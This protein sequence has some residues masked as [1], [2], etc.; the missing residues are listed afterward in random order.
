M[1]MTP[2]RKGEMFFHD[3][4]LCFQNW[5]SCSSCHP[6]ART[7]GLNWDL[8]NDGMGN[9]KQTKSMLLAHRT[10]P[11]MMGAVRENAEAA[12]RAGIRF[13]QFS[14]RPEE[15]AV[16]IDEYLKSLK[17]VPSPH[18]VD[19][20]LSDG[21]K[22]GEALFVST[23]CASCHVPP[24]FT[25]LQTH[26]VGTGRNMDKDRKFDTP[27]IIENWRTAPYLYDG[28]AATMMDV[29]KRCNPADAH[30]KTSALTPDQL[31]DLAAYILSQ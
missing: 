27:T 20:R 10:P 18:L 12:V 6:D 22:R 17:P 28:R 7:D 25:D 24:L 30:G 1:A 11:A 15:D 4:D 8:L 19:G 3:A 23:G 31:S 29:I 13:I 14:V 5:Q 21:A 9:P 2:V 26:D 16:A